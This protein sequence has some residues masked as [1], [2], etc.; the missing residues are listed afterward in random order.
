M[1]AIDRRV[2]LVLGRSAGGIA[3][4]VKEIAEALD[5]V[6]GLSIE[7]AGP[8]DLPIEMPKEI[9]PLR[10]PDGAIVGHRSAVKELRTIVS[11]V[12]CDVVHAHG[13]RAGIDA[14]LATRGLDTSVILTVHNL[15]QPEIAGRFKAPLFR[16][17]ETVAARTADHVLCVSEQIARHLRSSVAAAASKIEVLY[18]G[19]QDPP[20]PQRDPRDV[21]AEAGAGNPGQ[22]LIV[23]ASRLAPQ[24]ALHV[25]LEAIALVPEVHLVVLGEGPLESELKATAASLGVD[26]RT[27]FLGFRGDAHEFVAAADTFCLS[28]IWEGIPLAAQEAIALGTPVV[29]T[30]VGGM[31]EL[32]RDRHSGRLCPP[33]D[34]GA[35]AAAIQEVVTDRGTADRYATTARVELRQRFSRDRMLERLASLYK[36]NIRVP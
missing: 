3:R 36:E 27:V 16:K 31:D 7:I 11:S 29:A 25:L 18:L 23:T 13:L 34:A 19:I 22:R 10:I 14:A 24:K 35:L 5:E 28:S 1:S 20:E 32:I 12:G 17:A 8:P 33:G 30:D 9:H 6:G 4:H 26:D 15:V 2:L 21:R